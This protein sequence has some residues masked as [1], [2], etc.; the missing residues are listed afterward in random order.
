MYSPLRDAPQTDTHQALAFKLQRRIFVSVRVLAKTSSWS[1]KFASS[2]DCDSFFRYG[3]KTYELPLYERTHDLRKERNLPG[4][5]FWRVFAKGHL[6]RIKLGLLN[7]YGLTTN[8]GNSCVASVTFWTEHRS[9]EMADD[10]NLEL[11]VP[12]CEQR[13]EIELSESINALSIT[14]KGKLLAAGTMDNEIAVIDAGSGQLKFCLSGHKGGTNCVAFLNGAILISCGEDGTAK[15]WNI[16]HQKCVV[17]LT[18]DGLDADKSPFGHTVN[19]LTISPCGKK[20][21]VSS[22]RT[23]ALFTILSAVNGSVSLHDIPPLLFTLESL[24]FDPKNG[25]LLAAYNSGVT[26]WDFAQRSEQETQALDFPYEGPCLSVAMS[27]STEWLVAG[28][29]DATVHIWQLIPKKP[30]GVEVHEMACGGYERAVRATDFDESGKRLASIGGTRGTI[31]D[32]SKTPAGTAPTLTLGH[33]ATVTCQAW[34]PEE[35]WLLA[36]AAKNGGVL[37]HDVDDIAQPG[38]PNLCLPGAVAPCPGQPDEATSLI[39]GVDGWFF[40]GHVS[41]IV[42]AWKLAEVE[43]EDD[44]EDDQAR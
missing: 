30:E 23:V 43:E 11:S 27:P 9:L 35:P 4:P 2:S 24:R 44:E 33:E 41:G 13:W 40:V 37:L 20:F 1:S 10:S 14:P 5:W 25:N 8:V 21:A 38:E 15:V 28:C 7:S 12:E 22:G 29:H 39:W 26:V 31:W 17:E 32:F 42:R 3:H 6:K 34:Q 16:A 18:I 19:N 36:S